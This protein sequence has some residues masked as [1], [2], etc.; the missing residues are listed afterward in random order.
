MEDCE[1]LF[2]VLGNEK[3]IAEKYLARRLLGIQQALDNVYL[4]PGP[5]NAADGPNEVESDMAP[6]LRLLQSGSF[7]HRAFRPLRVATF[8]GDTSACI[9]LLAVVAF[10]FC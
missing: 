3:T 8:M 1:S 5:E 2:T 6:L 7:S 4:L 10:F 9:F